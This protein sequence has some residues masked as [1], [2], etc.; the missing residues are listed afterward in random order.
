MTKT[1]WKQ[2]VGGGGG[3]GGERKIKTMLKTFWQCMKLLNSMGYDK[4]CVE[5]GG[6]R[7][8]GGG[9][10]LDTDQPTHLL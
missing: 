6:G 7:G 5:T 10:N 9:G 4:N 1:V 3:G 8:G 2:R